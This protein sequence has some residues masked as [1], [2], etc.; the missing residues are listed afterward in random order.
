MLGVYKG[1]AVT[2]LMAVFCTS[3][4]AEDGISG[5]AMDEIIGKIYD[6][7]E[8]VSYEFFREIGLSDFHQVSSS[9]SLN[10][11]FRSKAFKTRDQYAISFVEF[12]VPP[13][14]DKGVSFM[15][16]E[17]APGRCY[18]VSKIK[19][20]FALTPYVLPPNPHAPLAD[21]SKDVFYK[22]NL[23]ETSVYV[24]ASSKGE[25]LLGLTRSR[26]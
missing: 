14:L 21:V 1:L 17:L 18:E 25:C 8:P 13:E 3:A 7:S 10:I 12:R 5:L 23:G 15:Y 26:N 2:L 19:Q 16:M 20:K 9:R 11:A 24:K 6:P 22:T 4:I